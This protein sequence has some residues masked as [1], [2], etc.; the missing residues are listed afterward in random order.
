M[1]CVLPGHLLQEACLDVLDQVGGAPA[2]GVFSAA[3]EPVPVLCS[4]LRAW[5]QGPAYSERFIMFVQ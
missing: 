1:N 3:E 5:G 4:L 2:L